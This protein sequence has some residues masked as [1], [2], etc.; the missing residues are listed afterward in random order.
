[1]KSLRTM[2]RYLSTKGDETLTRLNRRERSQVIDILLTERGQATVHTPQDPI[3]MKH[4]E[5]EIYGDGKQVSCCL[6]PDIQAQAAMEQP[7]HF[8]MLPW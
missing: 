3:C 6:E 1:M 7:A 5:E 4:P 2:E 8:L